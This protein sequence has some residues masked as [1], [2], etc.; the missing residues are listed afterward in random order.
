MLRPLTGPAPRLK[1]PP[2][3]C[4]T[5]MHFYGNAYPRH[6]DGP[7]PAPDATVPDYKQLMKWLGLERVVV[8]QANAYGDDNRC[9]IDAVTELGLDKA[10]AVVVVKPSVS[11]AE[12]DRLT[13]AGA[14]GVRIMT[15]PGGHLKFDVMDAI[16]ARVQSFGW[17]P[18]VQLDGR[19]FEQHEAQLK[20]IK[21]NYIIDHTGKFLE[22]VAT[23]SPAFKAFLRLLDR[24]NCY[25]K[26]SAPYETSKIGPPTYSDVCAIT[27]ALVKA[28]PERMLYASNWP[29]PSEPLQRYP[30][31][32]ALLDLFLE[33]MPDERTRQA[34]FVDNPARLYGF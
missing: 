23:D 15:L 26:L 8:V 12:L 32:A 17:H 6:P 20:T 19:N 29:H 4:D 28:A 5:H 9:V 10:R 16:L 33:T 27:K 21:G 2:G 18:I 1:L 25:V 30:N 34:T 31:D 11:D 24:G 22:P 3:A 7:Q 13:K 14:R